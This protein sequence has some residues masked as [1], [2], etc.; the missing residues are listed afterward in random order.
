MIGSRLVIIAATVLVFGVILLLYTL[1]KTFRWILGTRDP[2][3]E[4]FKSFELGRKA[5][6]TVVAILLLVL[7]QALFGLSRTLHPFVPYGEGQPAAVVA[8]ERNTTSTDYNVRFVYEPIVRSKDGTELSFGVR[9]VITLW[10]DV[11]CFHAEQIRF[12]GLFG[13][14]GVASSFRIDRVDAIEMVPDTLHGG[15]GVYASKRIGGRSALF[16]VLDKYARFMP[17]VSVDTFIVEV[18]A[19]AESG[20][21]TLY[22]SD[23]GLRY[24]EGRASF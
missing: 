12:P 21:F 23:T 19:V 4:R 20:V 8:Y 18:P 9:D 15:S 22:F 17:G 11:L 10:G 3:A 6:T 2:R 13:Y 24:E 7:S 5:S 1:A 16:R 14:L